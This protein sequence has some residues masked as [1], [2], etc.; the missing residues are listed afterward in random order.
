MN[1]GRAAAERFRGNRRLHGYARGKTAWDPA[2]PAIAERAFGSP[3]PLL[4]VGCG[5]GLLAAYLREAGCC[6]TLIGIEPDAAKVQLAAERVG[7]Y[8]DNVRFEVGEAA[9]MPDFSG[10]VVVLDV[11]HYLDEA[12]QAEFLRN[13]VS[14]I[15]PGGSAW[16]RTTFR[17]AHWRFAVTLAEEAFVR[18]TGW[19]RGGRCVF[20]RRQMILDTL[21]STGFAVTV[22]PMWGRTPFNSHLITVKRP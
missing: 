16:I 2:Y 12:G 7:G 6:Q 9:R 4:D 5:V 8:Y 3:R 14:R 17:E 13:I 21:D 18:L 10:D 20:P 15:A 22:E 19:I 11:L 1:P